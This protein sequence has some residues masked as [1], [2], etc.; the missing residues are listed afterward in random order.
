MPKRDQKREE[1]DEKNGCLY[2]DHANR[3]KHADT[4]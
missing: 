2:Y 3:K 1:N 4:E